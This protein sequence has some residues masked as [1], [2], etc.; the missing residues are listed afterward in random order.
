MEVTGEERVGAGAL[1]S[2]TVTFLLTDVAGST[3]LWQAEP[4]AMA[5]AIS[6]HYEILDHVIVAHGGSRP[7]EQGEGDSVVG[8]FP[9]SSSAVLAALDAQRR[10]QSE[11][12]PTTAPLK[13][14]MAVHIGDALLRDGL[15]YVGP[16]IIRTARLRA[17]AHGGQVLVSGPAR[18]LAVDDLPDDLELR[19][20]GVHRLKDLDRAE[21][22]W[23]LVHPEIDAV[24]PPP[25]SLDAA[26]NNLP[27]ALSPFIGRSDEIGTVARLILDNGW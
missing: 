8:V 12:W 17:I 10:L 25:R 24:F 7:I 23:Q 18:E 15:D 13:V 2:G 19:D 11:A 20:L 6:R 21:H 4:E 22:V 27:V 9:R 16:G 14:R 26:R 5:R 1:P 3:G